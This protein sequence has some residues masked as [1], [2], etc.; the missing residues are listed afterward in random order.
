MGG[1]AAGAGSLLFAAFAMT[2]PTSRCTFFVFDV[3]PITAPR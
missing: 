1:A 3:D 2:Y